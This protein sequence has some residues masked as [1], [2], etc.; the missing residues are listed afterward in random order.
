MNKLGMK[1]TRT[2]NPIALLLSRRRG[3]TWRSIE[4]VFLSRIVGYD[5]RILERQSGLTCQVGAGFKYEL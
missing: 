4:I 5:D 1:R 2:T 3:T